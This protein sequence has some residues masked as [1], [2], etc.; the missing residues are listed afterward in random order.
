V[1]MYPGLLLSHP[2]RKER[3]KDGAREIPVEA[4]R[5]LAL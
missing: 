3:E 5:D 4:V 1:S 2:F